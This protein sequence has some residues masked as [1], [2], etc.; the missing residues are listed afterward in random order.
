VLV[1]AERALDLLRPRLHDAEPQVRTSAAAALSA[2][3]AHPRFIHVLTHLR[4]RLDSSTN[5][6]RER[7]AQLLGMFRDVGSVPALI[8][9]LDDKGAAREAA[10]G[11]LTQIA[12][13]D[14]GPKSKSW[15]KWWERARK[16][17]RI[18]WLIDA[19]KSKEADVRFLAGAELVQITGTDF[20]YGS[21]RSARERLEAIRRVEK[22]W[23][24]ER[25]ALGT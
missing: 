20:G 25:A 8:A 22:W 11:A 17:T 12:L 7:A 13:V 14:H 24:D 4:Q 5:D 3:M 15:L 9:M 19:L 16:S 2:F 10:H 23:H 1:Q 6:A 18:D 21:D